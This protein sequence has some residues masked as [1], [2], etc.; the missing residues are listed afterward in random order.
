MFEQ[1]EEDVALER[2]GR[3]TMTRA[4]VIGQGVKLA[5]SVGAVSAMLL[6]NGFDLD[7]HVTRTEAAAHGDTGGGPYTLTSV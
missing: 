3:D 6:G 5:L 7:P 4:E 1:R 2:A